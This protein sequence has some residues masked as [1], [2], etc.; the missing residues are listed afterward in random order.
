MIDNEFV[1]LGMVELVLTRHEQEETYVRDLKYYLFEYA[2]SAVCEFWIPHRQILGENDESKSSQDVASE[3]TNTGDAEA[4]PSVRFAKK[5]MIESSSVA[6]TSAALQDSD[7]SSIGST[8]ESITNSQPL[9]EA[10]NL[11]E[12]I[13]I[14][15]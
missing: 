12:Q 3:K 13:G 6:D 9:V 1:V 8:K 2:Q 4:S 11:E 15:Y 7:V 10:Q 5:V 14:Y